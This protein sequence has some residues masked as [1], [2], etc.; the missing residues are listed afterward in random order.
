M[1]V[2]HMYFEATNEHILKKCIEEYDNLPE[3]SEGRVKKSFWERDFA[4][5][6]S[7]MVYVLSR[8][9]YISCVFYF[10][11]F[12]VLATQWVV[13]VERNPTKN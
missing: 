9:F 11:P 6:M 7:R 13:D 1:E 8:T 12:M 4:N 2:T 3:R 5:K 10:V